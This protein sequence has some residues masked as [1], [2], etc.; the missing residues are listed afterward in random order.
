VGSEVISLETGTQSDGALPAY[1]L[2][3]PARNEAAFIELTIESVVS[4]SVRPLR[5]VIASDGSTDGTDEIVKKHAAVH[6]WIELVRLPERADRNFAG[7]V[8]AFNAG[9]GRAA[10]LPFDV[11]GSLDADVSFDSE[12]FAFLLRK[13]AEDPTLGIVG[14]PFKG[15]SM[16]DYRYV[17]VEHVSGA[18]QVFRR[19]C[20]EAIG[21]YI[22]MKDGGIDHVAV[23]KAR[24]NGWKTK[25]FTDKICLHHRTIGSAQ[26]S[27]LAARFHDGVLDSALGGHPVW[28]VFRTLYQMTRKP[29]II[30]GLMIGLGYLARTLSRVPRPVTDELVAFRR[31]EQI[32]RLRSRFSGSFSR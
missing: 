8:H 20:F 9:F 6:A 5:W 3:T 7:K 15:E 28:E 31:R 21:G 22:P 14:T 11:V 32:A 1:V 24:M 4:Q 26:R 19:E 18:C 29:Y 17:S 12:Y 13:L 16:Y 2:V 27:L 10:L 30:G 25:T 23:I